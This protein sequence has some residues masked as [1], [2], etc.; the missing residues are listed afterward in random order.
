M[1]NYSYFGSLN[2]EQQSVLVG[3]LL[4]DGCL[5][6]RGTTYPRLKLGHC[7]RQKEYLSWKVEMFGTLFS[8]SVLKPYNTK[9]GSVEFHTCSRTH[10]V[11]M[12]YWSLFY[13][14]PASECTKHVLKKRITEQVLNLV[15]DLALAVWF[16]DDGYLEQRRHITVGSRPAALLYLGGV[17]PFE[18]DLVLNW[19]KNKGFVVNQIHRK[20]EHDNYEALRFSVESTEDFIKRISRYVPRCMA[21]KTAL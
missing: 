20:G 7:E 12:S 21:Y 1:G 16:C 6:L 5:Q 4:G 15:D 3:T 11:F 13:S 8:S 17:T 2:Q 19:I 10:P 14:R 18:H 9:Y